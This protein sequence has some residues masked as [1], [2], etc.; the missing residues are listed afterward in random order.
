MVHKKQFNVP[1][2][3]KNMDLLE[4]NLLIQLKI[5]RYCVFK[6]KVKNTMCKSIT[7]L[8]YKIIR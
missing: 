4:I 2:N 6:M 7:K 5:F 8:E 3:I 1:I